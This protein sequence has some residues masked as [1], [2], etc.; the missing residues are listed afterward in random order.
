[1]ASDVLREGHRTWLSLSMHGLEQGSGFGAEKAFEGEGST[2]H[3][4]G[5]QGKPGACQA[6]VQCREGNLGRAPR[7]PTRTLRGPWALQDLCPKVTFFTGFSATG[8]QLM[9]SQRRI[10]RSSS[11]LS[12]HDRPPWLTLPL[13][14][15]KLRPE[16]QWDQKLRGVAETALFTTPPPPPTPQGLSRGMQTL[17]SCRSPA[18]SIQECNL[19]TEDLHHSFLFF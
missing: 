5:L 6:W 14:T 19:H 13:G 17:V 11:V 16:R 2:N 18:L 9:S 4:E 1:M 8:T 12:Q 3:V 7:A 15:W 10:S